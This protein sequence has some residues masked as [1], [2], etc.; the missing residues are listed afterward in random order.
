MTNV[1]EFAIPME[2]RQFL[3]STFKIYNIRARVG[4]FKKIEFHV[5][6]GDHNPPHVHAIFDHKYQISISLIDFKVI[7]GN[8]PSK[9]QNI[10]IKWV[11]KNQNKLLNEWNRL[12]ISSTLTLVKSNLDSKETVK[13]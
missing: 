10:A 13:Q 12:S 1:N 11:K 6:S 2:I 7:A 5:R 8:L 9:N 4:D 3:Q